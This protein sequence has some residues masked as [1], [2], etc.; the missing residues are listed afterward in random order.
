[1]SRVL[2]LGRSKQVTAAQAGYSS[3]PSNAGFFFIV[4]P[5]RR[6]PCSDSAGD[7]LGFS[8][9]IQAAPCRS[10][11]ST[12]RPSGTLRRAINKLCFSSRKRPA[13]NRDYFDCLTSNL[14]L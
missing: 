9:L 3:C 4:Q 7:C 5:E 11:Q 13:R 12:A 2:Y 14:N 6:H 1:M 10:Q 8:K